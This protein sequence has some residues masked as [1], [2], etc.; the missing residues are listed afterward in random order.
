[1]FEQNGKPSLNGWTFHPAIPGDTANFDDTAP[2]GSG[3]TWSIK[4]HKADAPHT[5][6]NVTEGFTNLTSG[7]YELSSWLMTKYE[8]FAG[9][10]STQGWIAVIRSRNG[11]GDTLRAFAGSDTNWHELDLFDTLSLV[12]TDSVILELSAAATDTSTHGNPMWFDDVTFK[13]IP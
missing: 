10:A 4:L 6:N 11:M 1:M 5:T 8:G 13:K 12:P 2:P 3:G 9:P 7:I